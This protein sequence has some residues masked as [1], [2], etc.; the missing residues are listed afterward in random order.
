MNRANLNGN[1]GR[2]YSTGSRNPWEAVSAIPFG[3]EWNDQGRARVPWHRQLKR[4]ASKKTVLCLLVVQ[5]P[6]TAAR[7]AC[8]PRLNQARTPATR[9]SLTWRLSRA[10]DGVSHQTPRNPPRV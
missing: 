7:G 4:N 8:S 9:Y 6:E 5:P 10:A 2:G 3:Q 1:K